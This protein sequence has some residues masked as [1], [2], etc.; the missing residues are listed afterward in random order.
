[1]LKCAQ[2]LTSAAESYKMTTT[3]GKA[4]IVDILLFV[5]KKNLMLM[6]VEHG[7]S[8]KTSGHVQTD[9]LTVTSATEVPKAYGRT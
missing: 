9:I 4:F 6:L 1:M 2:H 5:S 7:E 3:V 8:L